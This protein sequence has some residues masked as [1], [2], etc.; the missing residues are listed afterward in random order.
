M[1]RGKKGLRKIQNSDVSYD[2]VDYLIFGLCLVQ[3]LNH[4]FSCSKIGSRFFVPDFGLWKSTDYGM[5]RFVPKIQK[6]FMI[7]PFFPGSNFT[8]CSCIP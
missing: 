6:K 3:S 7:F 2:V 8:Q 4:G 5:L 1:K